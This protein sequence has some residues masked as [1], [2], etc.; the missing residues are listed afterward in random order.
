MRLPLRHMILLIIS[1]ARKPTSVRQT[2]LTSP[3]PSVRVTVSWYSVG[4]STDHRDTPGASAETVTSAAAGRVS[5]TITLPWASVS[6]TRTLPSG[7]SSFIS[8]TR[9]ARV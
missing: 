1:K 3:A 4:A 5:S 8:A 2:S 6:V 9:E 7:R